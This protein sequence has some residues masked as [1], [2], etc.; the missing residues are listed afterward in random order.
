MISTKNIT[1]SY[2]KD[3][4]FHM[5][6]IFCQAGNT[7]L[8]TGNSGKGKTTYL[9]ILAGLL[10]PNSG[11]III[12]GKNI[13]G[14]SESKGDNYRGKHIGVVFQKSHFIAALTVLENLEMASWLATG[15]KH[16]KRAKDLL[17]KLDIVE[18]ANKLPSQLS[19]GQ[20][21]RV[22]IARA[23]MNEPKVL[24]A[25]E[26]TSSLD[27]SNAEKVINLLESLSKEYHAALII[28]THDSRIKQRFTNQITM[29]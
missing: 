1:F 27:D 16:S 10:K 9:H 3:Q 17:A 15:K 7:I 25:D 12:D 23:L 20:Q 14:L 8:V 26:P 21:Q 11:E 18:Q 6:D 5:P 13:V 22:S 29:V 4:V 24:L 19:I 2:Q 28:V